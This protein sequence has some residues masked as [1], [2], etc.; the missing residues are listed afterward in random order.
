MD[1]DSFE[2]MSTE[3]NTASSSLKTLMMSDFCCAH[4]SNRHTSQPRQSHP[5][6]DTQTDVLLHDACYLC[7]YFR[8]MLYRAHESLRERAGTHVPHLLFLGGLFYSCVT[9]GSVQL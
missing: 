5:K 4:R 6:C 7:R 8:V 1:D 3:S 2:L 9:Q